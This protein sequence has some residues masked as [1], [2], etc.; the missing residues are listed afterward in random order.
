MP[1]G[2]PR[3]RTWVLATAAVV[4]A[5]SAYV[6]VRMQPVA[7]APT[8][9]KLTIA[10]PDVPHAGLL[11]IAVEQGYYTAEGLDVTIVPASH[12]K[13]AMEELRRGKADL[14]VT[15]EA[16]FLLAVM[17]GE[18]LGIAASVLNVSGDNAV[19]ARRDRNIAVPR[20][21]AGKR[22]G[23]TFGTSGEYF[24]WAFLVR[25]KLAPEAVTLVDLPPGRIAAALAG[26]DVDAIATWAPVLAEARA[27]L[28][29]NAATF[30]EANVYTLNF[31]LSG[32]S[33]FLRA[34]PRA[35]EKLLRA[36]LKAEE[37]SRAHPEQALLLVAKR[38]KVDADVLRPNWNDFNFRVDL[39][40]SQLVT[41]EDQARWAMA[42]GHVARGPVPN[43]LPHF[44]LDA[45]LAVRPD[46]VSVVH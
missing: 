8:I 44:Y 19:V 46:R 6:L 14:A 3:R 29:T 9:E 1:S 5:A 12:G 30:A 32:R 39:R 35:L 28:G 20:D 13:A 38:L 34:H 45:L 16:V 31:L 4:L 26:G 7:P 10:L 27:A 21:L 37:F 40:Q 18:A 11:H 24:L 23:V 17:K 43:L 2:T 36:L 42:R 41:L 22:L 25:H 33:E 15:A